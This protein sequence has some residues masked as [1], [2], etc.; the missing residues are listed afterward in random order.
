MGHHSKKNNQAAAAP[1]QFD[2][3]TVGQMLSNVDVNAMSNM[4]NS[5]D[6]NQVMSVLQ[7][8]FTPPANPIPTPAMPQ[9]ESSTNEQ[10]SGALNT[11][12]F[13]FPFPMFSQ[14]PSPQPQLNP[15][16]PSNEPVVLILNS[17]KPFLPPDKCLIIDD[18]VKLLGIKAVVDA[19]FP[20]AAVKAN[21]S[22]S[23]EPD[24]SETNGS[25]KALEENETEE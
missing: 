13:N 17:L 16:L 18:L 6:M 20:P 3:N 14:S 12:N 19:I 5:I 7:K 9:K 21:I 1:Q 2:L 15:V 8:S 4:L 24:Q 22:R 23:S 10:P 11:G 25:K